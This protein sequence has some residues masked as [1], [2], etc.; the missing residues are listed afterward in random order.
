MWNN[1]HHCFKCMVWIHT[2]KESGLRCYAITFKLTRVRFGVRF[3]AISFDE[4][5]KNISTIYFRG[6]GV[7]HVVIFGSESSHS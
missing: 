7:Y 4:I 1:I 5:K 3:V 2:S 6:E